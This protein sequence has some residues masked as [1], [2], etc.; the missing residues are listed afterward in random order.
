MSEVSFNDRSFLGEL[1]QQYYDL[2]L[3]EANKIV[4]NY[5]D[6]EDVVQDFFTY[7]L[8]HAERIREVES[9]AI[10]RFLIACIKRK[11][12]DVLRRRETRRKYVI[13]SA[14]DFDYMLICT[15]ETLSV[16]ESALNRIA[17]E[18]VK[19]ALVLLS[20]NQQHAMEYKYFRDMTDREIAKTMGV[21]PC[22]VRS[23]LTRARKKMHRICVENG[24]AG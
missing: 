17:V 11:S 13:D 20:K 1:Y 22:S 16:E 8:S 19:D 4:H 6:A 24:Y 7:A 15:D 14:D 23:N 3:R 12:I 5:H 18:D 9:N 21:R 10:C 2:L